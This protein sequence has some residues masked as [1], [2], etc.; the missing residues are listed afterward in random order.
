MILIEKFHWRN[1]QNDTLWWS[2]L[3]TGRPL[4]NHE[5]SG[6][7][8]PVTRVSIRT[9]FPSCTSL[10]SGAF[11]NTGRERASR[12]PPSSSGSVSFLSLKSYWN[13]CTFSQSATITCILSTMLFCKLYFYDTPEN[14]LI[15]QFRWSL[16]YLV[17]AFLTGWVFCPGFQVPQMKWH[18]CFQVCPHK[19]CWNRCPSPGCWQ[20][21]WCNVRRP[22]AGPCG[23]AECNSRL[24]WISSHIGL[25]FWFYVHLSTRQPDDSNEVHLVLSL[26]ILFTYIFDQLSIAMTV[27]SQNL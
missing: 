25:I 20:P 6:T 22:Q 24:L 13:T 18:Q 8:R 11:L 12:I 21:V 27:Q 10:S 7:G 9:V 26:L 15:R 16:K 1:W 19:V 4:R 3:W 17:S 14:S 5:S 2:S 23:Y